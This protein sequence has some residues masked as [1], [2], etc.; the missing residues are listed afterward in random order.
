VQQIK[1][2]E[3]SKEKRR[4]V[5]AINKWKED[6][7]QK[8]ENAADLSDFLKKDPGR[9]SRGGRGRPDKAGGRK[10]GPGSKVQKAGKKKIAKRPGKQTRMKSKSKKGSKRH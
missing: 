10:G 2:L 8:G 6:I 7:R 5:E 4:N 3:K 1:T 9:P